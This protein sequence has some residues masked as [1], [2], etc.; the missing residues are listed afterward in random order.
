MVIVRLSH[1]WVTVYGMNQDVGGGGLQV[2]GAHG[3]ASCN[4]AQRAPV[5]SQ[6]V[7]QE[8]VHSDREESNKSLQLARDQRGQWSGYAS[9]QV[10][11]VSP[12]W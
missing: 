6:A 2:P 1:S 5:Y 4:L 3:Q 12:A 8:S 7:Q 11:I 10:S 9:W